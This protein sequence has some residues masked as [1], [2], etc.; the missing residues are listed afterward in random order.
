MLAAST[1]P[2]VDRQLAHW[3]ET[4]APMRRLLDMLA[5]RLAPS[6][7][8]LLIGGA[9]RDRLLANPNGPKDVDLVTVGTG[10]EALRSALPQAT[11]NFFGGLN[12]VHDGIAV[13]IWPLQHT[14]HIARYGLAPTVANLLAGAPFN[15]DKA[16]FNV[17]R[18][19]FDGDALLHGI[20]SRQIVYA[21]RFPYLE[22]IQ[23][24]RCVL[25]RKKTGFS[26]APSANQL[27][28]RAAESIERD[29]ALRDQADRFLR[30]ADRVAGGDARDAILAEI[31]AAQA[32]PALA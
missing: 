28:V 12:F 6:T 26:L 30:N 4:D 32:A 25:L 19:R 22:H 11:P 14:Y 23:A 10:D 27:L 1:S 3:L 29:A 15:L 13:D 17:Q 2:P 24:A 21:P 7:Q 8:I 31:L 18:G 16:V 5:D 20:A 9:L